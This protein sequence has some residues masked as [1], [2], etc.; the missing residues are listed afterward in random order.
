MTS[1][2]AHKP[3]LSNSH[4]KVAWPLETWSPQINTA[5]CLPQLWH[6]LHSVWEKS[7]PYRRRDIDWC[8][9][10]TGDG[11]DNEFTQ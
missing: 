10:T 1:R 6:D 4:V 5:M 7:S 9:P 3:V 2:A 8:D 11:H